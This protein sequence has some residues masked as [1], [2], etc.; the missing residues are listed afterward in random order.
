[1]DQQE[2]TTSN[3]VSQDTDK[4]TVPMALITLPQRAALIEFMAKQPYTDVANG[5]EFLRSAPVIDVTITT[6]DDAEVSS[7]EE[8]S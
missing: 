1:M 7:E 8:I 2:Q 3:E 4:Q 5:I 6:P